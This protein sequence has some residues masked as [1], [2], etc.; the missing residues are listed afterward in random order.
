MSS[1]LYLHFN[2]SLHCFFTVRFLC[3]YLRGEISKSWVWTP[4]DWSKSITEVGAIWQIWFLSW[5]QLLGELKA[6][7][8]WVE[9]SPVEST[10]GPNTMRKATAAACLAK[11]GAGNTRSL[12]SWESLSLWTSRVTFKNQKLCRSSEKEANFSC[13][14]NRNLNFEGE[15]KSKTWLCRYT[16]FLQGLVHETLASS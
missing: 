14:I 11:L 6:V 5:A 3:Y 15:S 1:L 9:G 8:I 7:G 12:T 10:L 2:L 16:L 13:Q 4:S